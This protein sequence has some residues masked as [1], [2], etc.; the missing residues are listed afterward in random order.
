ME[1]RLDGWWL[2][3]G[4]GGKQCPK[5]VCSGR[6]DTEELRRAGEC[7][8][9]SMHFETQKLK[10]NMERE[11]SSPDS[12]PVRRETPIP[13]HSNFILTP[14]LYRSLNTPLFV[15]YLYTRVDD[16]IGQ[17]YNGRG[18]REQDSRDDNAGNN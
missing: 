15:L 17:P 7:V 13:H 1:R 3:V 6:S 9:H 8:H 12:P 16:D 18:G 10:K 11:G 14:G 4:A 2:N 5:L